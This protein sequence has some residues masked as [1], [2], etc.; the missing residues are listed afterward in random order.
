[1][2]GRAR[3]LFYGLCTG[4][5]VVPLRDDVRSRV[6]RERLFYDTHTCMLC[7]LHNTKYTWYAFPLQLRL[8]KQSRSRRENSWCSTAKAWQILLLLL[9]AAKTTRST[10]T[11][12]R[13]IRGST[14]GGSCRRPGRAFRFGLRRQIVCVLLRRGATSHVEYTAD[15]RLLREAC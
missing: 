1:M 13:E 15:V 3:P 12:V 11:C 14:M 5:D 10:I 9:S 4:H 2:C 8:W 7:A 6:A